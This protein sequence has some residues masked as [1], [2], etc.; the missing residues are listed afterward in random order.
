MASLAVAAEPTKSMTAQTAPPAAST[1]RC[2]E[3]GWLRLAIAYIDDQPAAAQIWIVSNGVA[4][5]YKLS[6]DERFAKFSL[7]TLLTAHLME[8]AIDVD[9]VHEID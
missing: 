7:G 5:I 3:S 4:N 2:A 1:R 6:Y 8:H 9:K